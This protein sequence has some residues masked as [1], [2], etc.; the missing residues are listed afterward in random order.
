M[1]VC[2]VQKPMKI[3]IEVSVRD[4]MRVEVSRI[5]LIFNAEQTA[6][7][8]TEKNGNDDDNGLF[9]HAVTFFRK[10]IILP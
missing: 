4:E 7:A 8:A 9:A 1:N 6:A 5:L 3:K 10:C 2:V